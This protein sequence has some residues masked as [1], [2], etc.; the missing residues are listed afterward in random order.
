MHDSGIVLGGGYT[1]KIQVPGWSCD[2]DWM[3]Q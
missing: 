3:S 1:F 2:V